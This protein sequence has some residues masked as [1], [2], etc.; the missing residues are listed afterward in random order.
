MF[1]LIFCICKFNELITAALNILIWGRVSFQERKGTA[2]LDFLRK[3]EEEVQQK[4]EQ[5]KIFETDA[6][7]TSEENT[8]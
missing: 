5:E 1:I 7:A 2:K 4:W 8:K 3:I 6:P